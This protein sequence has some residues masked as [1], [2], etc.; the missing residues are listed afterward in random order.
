MAQMKVNVDLL[1][2]LSVIMSVVSLESFHSHTLVP[3]KYVPHLRMA[4]VQHKAQMVLDYLMLTTFCL[5]QHL[6]HVS[7]I[8]KTSPNNLYVYMYQMYY[9]NS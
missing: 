5:Y 7:S 3:E 9:F 2:H 6:P 8:T 4:H 1:C